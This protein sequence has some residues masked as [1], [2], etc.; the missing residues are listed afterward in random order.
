VALNFRGPDQVMVTLRVNDR[1]VQACIEP[2][3]T[4]LSVLREELGLTG[5]KRG[6]GQ[7][8]CGACTVIL[9]GETVY[10]C[11]T[12]AIECE[13]R[14][15]R[16]IEG[17]AQG[18]RLH[19]VQEAFIENDGYQCGFCTPGQVMSAVALLEHC[20]HPQRSTCVERWRGIHAAVGLTPTSF[21]RCWQPPKRKCR[22]VPAIKRTTV[23]Y[24]GRIEEREVIVEEERVKPWEE[25]AELW[26]VGQPTPRVDGVA[27]V[28]G[29]AIYTQ[30]VQLP[31][32]LIGRFLRSPYPHARVKRIDSTKAEAM[33]GV[34]LVWHRYQPPSVTRLV[35]REVFAEELAYQ[36][37]EV[38]FLVAH[39]ERTADDALAAIE[40]E[41][42]E[43]PFV[44]DLASATAEG[45]AEAL[46][47]VGGNLIAPHGQVYQRGSTEQG[48]R[49]ADVVVDLTFTTPIAAH[50]C[51]ETHGSV[52]KWEGDQLTLYHS[53][54]G[55]FGA[56]SMTAE[57]LDIRLD[58]VRVICDYMGGGFGSKFGVE[59]FSL[60]AA[61]AARKTGRPV[62]A[63]LDRAEEHL[64]AG[65]RPSSQQRVRLG[66]WRDGTLMF[67]E[68]EAW[69]VTGAFGG[70]GTSIGG[71]A[72]DLYACPNVRTVVWAV[73]ANTDAGRA[74]RAP[75]YVEGALAL[76]VA[77][78]ALAAD[79]GLDPL[80]LRL[81]NYAE[82][83]PARAIPYTR[84]ELRQAYEIG[85]DRI[86]WSTREQRC[87]QKGPWLRG[88]GM[89][90]QIWGGGGGPPASATAKL[91]PDGTAEV[92]VGVQDIGTG[93]KT[94]LAQ[95]A[96]QELGLPLD[97]V[98]C[99]VG[100][101]LATPF[102]PA[103]GGS[104]TLASTTPA[105]R[106]AGRDALRQL[107]DLAAHM[108]DLP[109]AT[110]EDFS[111]KEGEII[112]CLDSGKRIP[113]REVAA[114]MGDYMIIA[115][116]ARGPNPDGKAVNTFGAQFAEVEV[117]AET[118]QVRVLKVVS[119]HDIGRVANPLTATSQVYGGA[120]MGLGFGTMEERVIDY[121]TGLQ[122]TAN[123]EK[124]K[125]PTLAD[126]PEMDVTFLDL[127]DPEANSVGSK[128]LGEP[129]IIVT[130]AAIANAVADAIGV[131]ILYLPL[132]PDRVLRALREH[133]EGAR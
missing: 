25:G 60:L 123:S 92:M 71:P 23:E 55:I 30:D 18:E 94:I 48:L 54:Q 132:T 39:D 101:T 38:A 81:K 121:Q 73:R 118:G 88:W 59:S 72:R 68:H 15:I 103:S 62:K 63:L 105:V 53:T 27:R 102:G 5:A 2:R 98:R 116:G 113:F 86:G 91:L 111:V 36:G 117:N 83:S 120:T 34:W 42:E 56:R 64:V 19:P 67:I 90:S 85:A 110:A 44:H 93:T 79:L 84:K 8:E 95:V 17:L 65:Y 14:E 131:R 75:G 43:Y 12:L 4:L 26:I 32:M 122:L 29:Q 82:I 126:I 61:L 133:Q 70:A 112:C 127:A 46:M 52:A 97:A 106:A 6:C 80:A 22:T 66:A 37:A 115:K 114:R 128:G 89:A 78:D 57:A 1:R 77:M 9:D 31:G 11:L 58:K 96:A 7:G 40:V 74:F 100:D 99:V 28:T 35:G 119:V 13:G 87:T 69:I 49:D 21:G 10:A 109:D 51:L 16:T 3:R 20:P 107:L 50:C 104:V 45:A 76:E 130:P 41:Y 125:V 33:P 129:P 24:E 124:Y 47:G 108:L